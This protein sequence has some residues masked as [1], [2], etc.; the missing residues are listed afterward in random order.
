MPQLINN[1][2]IPVYASNFAFVDSTIRLKILGTESKIVGLIAR[3]SSFN[4]SIFPLAT[5]N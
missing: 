3:Q 4:L 5:L 1:F 2:F